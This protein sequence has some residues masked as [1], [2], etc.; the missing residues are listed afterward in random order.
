[1]PARPWPLL[2]VGQRVRIN[3]G[4]LAGYE[5]ILIASKKQYRLVVSVETVQRSVAIE[6]DAAWVELACSPARVAAAA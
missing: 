4:S 2:A 5:G 6:V 1:M 3:H